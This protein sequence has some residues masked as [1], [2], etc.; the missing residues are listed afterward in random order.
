MIFFFFENLKWLLIFL[1]IHE[2]SSERDSN[3]HN[4]EDEVMDESIRSGC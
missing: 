2:Y 3:L 1:L 4:F